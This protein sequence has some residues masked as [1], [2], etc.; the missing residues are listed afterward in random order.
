M[1]CVA[2]PDASV[3]AMAMTPEV[4]ATS[5]PQRLPVHR[6]A[7]TIEGYPWSAWPSVAPHWS[8]LVAESSVCSVF[9][10]MNWVE[11]WLTVFGPLLQPQILVFS[12]DEQPVGICLLV[13]RH[14]RRGPVPMVRLYLNTAGED[15]CDSVCVEYND[16][17]CLPGYEEAVARALHRYLGRLWWDELALQGF[18]RGPGLEALTGLFGR[19]NRQVDEKPS[20]YVDLEY[21]RQASTPYDQVL[22]SSTRR[23]IRRSCE[24]YEQAGRIAVEC[25]SDPA[26]AHEMLGQLARL[27]QRSWTARGQ[28][29][30]FGSPRFTGF[31][32]RLIEHAFPSGETQLLRVRTPRHIIGVLYNFVHGGRV[33]FYQS[34]LQYAADNRLKPGLV[35]HY[36][37]VQYCL[38]QGYQEYDFLAGDSRYK[39]AL[40]THA[41]HLEWVVIERDT[42]AAVIVRLLRRGKR[43]LAH[44]TSTEHDRSGSGSSTSSVGTDQ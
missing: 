25:A 33:Y 1:T 43:Y 9:L 21:L 38:A 30:V 8:R 16:L 37:A 14:Q 32:R 3:A 22:S 34:G 23:Q 39:R 24:L 42:P 5:D 12:Y 31:H 28:P 13:R 27:H 6:Y 40:A 17:V 20:Y 41:R 19:L 29:G 4:P 10:S 35:A 44:L 2:L 26:A 36:H 7:L 11:T 15:E 18:Q